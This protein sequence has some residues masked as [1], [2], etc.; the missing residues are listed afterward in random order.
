M[1]GFDYK[2]MFIWCKSEMGLGNY[3]RVSHELLLLGVRG[4]LEFNDKGLKSWKEI[5][6]S[7][8]HSAK[9]EPVR[10]LVEKASPGPRLELFGR[11]AVSGW[12]VWGNQVSRD[13]F[14]QEEKEE[15]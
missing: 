10:H 11:D 2:G 3:W 4:N 8:K 1:W 15:T 9:P 12:T 13:L 5:S 7:G 14:H 6:R